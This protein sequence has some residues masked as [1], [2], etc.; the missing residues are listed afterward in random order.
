MKS[1][2]W[3]EFPNSYL[4]ERLILN[5]HWTHRFSEQRC[6]EHHENLGR[7][8]IDKNDVELATDGTN[9]ILKSR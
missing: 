2:D 8:R 6:S 9:V 1:R 4:R 3:T 7:A 5:I